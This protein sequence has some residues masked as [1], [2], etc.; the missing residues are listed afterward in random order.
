M[1]SVVATLKVKDD[2]IEEA[3]SFL[4]QLAK[5]TLAKEPGTLAYTVHQRKDDP[6]TFVFYEKYENDQAFAQHGENLKAQGAGF[7]QI[8]AGRPEIVFLEEL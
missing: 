6:T 8:L 2:K 3:K 4:S 5:D 7:A 1:P